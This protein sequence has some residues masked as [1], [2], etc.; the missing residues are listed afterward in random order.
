MAKQSVENSKTLLDEMFSIPEGVTDLQYP[1]AGEYSVSESD[2]DAELI[3]D[4]EFVESDEM[5]TYIS[6]VGALDT[7]QVLEV[8]SPQEIRMSPA[9]DE[10]V[11]IILNVDDVY[12][13]GNYEVRV[14][15]V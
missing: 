8:L 14:T 4:D 5:D 6:P 13:A 1:D 12:G 11:D 7:P 2:Y 9:G 10:V 15:K 3:I